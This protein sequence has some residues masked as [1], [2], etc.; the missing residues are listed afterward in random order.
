MLWEND[1]YR[2]QTELTDDGSRVRA[3]NLNIDYIFRKGIN[4]N[5]ITSGNNSM[6]MLPK[7]CLFSSAS[8][9]CFLFNDKKTLLCTWNIEF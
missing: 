6:R 5:S 9:A 2:L 1:G 7:G 8:N 4:W 3:V